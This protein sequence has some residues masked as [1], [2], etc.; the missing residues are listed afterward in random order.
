[1]EWYLKVIR[2]NYANFSGR[3]RRSEY[4]Y[5]MLFNIV[6][7]ILLTSLTE[8]TELFSYLCLLYIFAIIIPLLAV[9]VRRLH[10]TG[11]SGWIM[12]LSFV[13]LGGLILLAFYC[14]DS[15]F[16]RNKYG[17]NPKRP[18]EEDINEIG[19]HPQY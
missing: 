12:L 6:I 16:G 15:E 1:M 4:W 9:T 17:P 13:P 8:I 10:D 3:A 5:F 11:R 19:K 14:T 7:L 18:Y 2:D